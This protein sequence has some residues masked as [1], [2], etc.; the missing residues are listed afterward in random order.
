MEKLKRSLCWLSLSCFALC[1]G[2]QVAKAAEWNPILPLSGLSSEVPFIAESLRDPGLTTRRITDEI[3]AQ[4]AEEEIAQ[5]SRELAIAKGNRRMEL[6]TE[7]YESLA[8]I[9]YFYED[10]L[11]GRVHSSMNAATINQRLHQARSSIQR[12]ASEVI[13]LSKNPKVE[14]RAYY[15]IATSRYLNDETVS[16]SLLSKAQK[17]M[18]EAQDKRSTWLETLL[19]KS[20]KDE[21][22]TLRDA[23][24]FGSQGRL[25]VLL[26]FSR[27]HDEGAKLLKVAGVQAAK[28]SGSDREKG[29]NA[30][31]GIWRQQQ[32]A[33]LKWS[34]APISP[35]SI[36]DLELGNAL[37]ERIVLQNTQVGNYAGALSFY[38]KLGTQYRGQAKLAAIE[39]RILDLESAQFQ[40]SK[41]P[42]AYEKALLSLSAQTESPQVFGSGSEKLH[43]DFRGHLQQRHRQLVSQLVSEAKQKQSLRT[44]RLEAI[45]MSKV[46]I[47]QSASEGEK[48]PMKADIAKLYV[49]NA[50]HG[51]AVRTY[52]ELKQAT[53]GQQAQGFLLLAMESQ[54]KLSEWPDQAPWNGIP[55]DHIEQRQVLSQMYQ[56]RFQVTGQWDELAHLGLLQANLGQAPKA[57][58]MWTDMLAKNSQGPHAA[59]AGGLMLSSYKT[60]KQWQKLEDMS[61]LAL[62]VQ[63]VPLFQDRALQPVQLLADALFEGGKEHFGNSRYPQ[64]ESKL[65]EFI[66]SYRSEGRRP[67]A[68][69]ILGKSFHNDNKHPVS[70]ETM[71][72]LVNEYPNGTFEREALLL[73]GSWSIAMAWEDQTIF[74][75]QKFATNYSRDPKAPEIRM[76]LIPLYMGREIYGNAIRAYMAQ[77]EDVQ[78]QREQRIEAALQAMAIEER[79]GEPEHAYWGARKAR[80]LSN[81]NPAVLAETLAFEARYAVSRNDMGRVAQI[82]AQLSRLGLND[83]AV[84]EALALT[85]F[86]L[87]ERDAEGTKQEIF[88]LEQTDPYQTLT[89]QYALFQK[90]RTAYDKVCAPGLS[91][92]CGLAMLRLSEIT[93][94]SLSAIEN[95]TIPQTL[96]AAQVNRFEQQKLAIIGTISQTAVRADA[97]AMG[98]SERGD[99]VPDVSQEIVVNTSNGSF[100]RSHGA[101]GNGYVQW[102]PVKTSAD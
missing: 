37:S 61:R 80:E 90:A 60:A 45:R 64:A 82:E 76:T 68:M 16:L 92:S 67:E 8:N 46:Y 14:S 36:K 32:G 12:Y 91:N 87:A 101:I 38:R 89:Q 22:H 73:G 39:E 13:T 17:N 23:A 97:A 78:V 9:A 83:R 96:E 86:M 85:R 33:R 75:Y 51:D 57:F 79:Y 56:E 88:N 26:Y 72:A 65:A 30:V 10:A 31:L 100:D 6:A 49:L 35:A 50:Q 84:V 94:N 29:L 34:E 19:K 98:V 59:R 11:A 48:I 15:H 71:Y 54:R 18:S 47:A 74:F 44:S 27:Q 41:N 7:L 3:Y 40:S 25:A 70:V 69:L 55:R 43:Q 99:V 102:L 58:K 1:A 77:A 81:N 42:Q 2:A 53:Q 62:K 63:L 21:G 4:K 5:L 52:M 24:S 93:R 28:L 20:K 66:K 95:L